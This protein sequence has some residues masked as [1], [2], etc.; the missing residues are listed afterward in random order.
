MTRRRWSPEGG[1]LSKEI[2]RQQW[3]F[4]ALETTREVEELQF[5]LSN[6]TVLELM[7]VPNVSGGVA[8]DYSKINQQSTS[9]TEWEGHGHTSL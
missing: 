7:I 1:G 4:S 2:V 9:C 3:S 8:L 6:V 5:D